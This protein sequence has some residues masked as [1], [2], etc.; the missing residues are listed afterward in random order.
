MARYKRKPVDAQQDAAQTV[1]GSFKGNTGNIE[2]DLQKL[3]EA[4]KKTGRRYT[5]GKDGSI[6]TYEQ[7]EPAEGYQFN[8]IAEAVAWEEKYIR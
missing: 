6:Y 7:Y 8:T 5:V 1:C 3:E 4:Q 2:E